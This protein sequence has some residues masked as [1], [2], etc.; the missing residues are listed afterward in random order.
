MVAFTQADE[1]YM[2]RALA[3]AARGRGWVEPNPMVGCVLVR[4]DRIVGEGYHRKFGGPHAEVWALRQAGRAAS[5]ATAY[6]TLEP[7]CH[8]GKTPPCTEALIS[9]RIGRV[10]AAMV[11]P[12]ASVCGKGAARLREAG[13]P[14]S[15]GLLEA[16]SMRLNG[17]YLKG[18][19]TGRPWVILKWA[20]SLDGR[21]ATRTGDSQWISGEA[22][23]AY[24]HRLRG[25][26]DAVIVGAGTVLAD[27]PLLTCRHSR[28]R[29]IA[30]RIVLDPSLRTPPNSK[31]VRTARQVPTLAI[32]DR[33]N[34]ESA[35]ARA[36]QKS[37]VELLGL[38]QLRAG[39][40]L[41]AL[42][43]ELGRR[44]M[45]NVFVEG[46][47]RTLGAFHDAGLADEAVVFVSRR[48]IGGGIPPLA[49]QGP[50][51]MADVVR[52]AWVE[53]RHLGDDDLYRLVLTDAAIT[54]SAASSSGRP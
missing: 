48:L 12:F 54:F 34:T 3:L 29:R 17:P 4:G 45:A 19:R 8:F 42:L 16:E 9:A 25:L 22:S 26:V 37:G 24:A 51:A 44:G 21:I 31:L 18:R 20:Q 5:G 40:D 46:G 39:L 52:P 23:R 6:V 43:D 30:T 27:D 7:C 13:I 32:T 49:G 1:R 11:D 50:P 33:K 2:R 35:Q 41:G 36:L 53:A 47:G 28:P 10:V 15:L 38:R 14:V